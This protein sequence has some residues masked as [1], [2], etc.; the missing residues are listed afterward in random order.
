MNYEYTSTS[1][2]DIFPVEVPEGCGWR[3]LGHGKRK[4]TI[5]TEFYWFWEREAPPAPPEPEVNHDHDDLFG[6]AR[7]EALE[8]K[9]SDLRKLGW[10][11][12]LVTAADRDTPMAV[13]QAR[14]ALKAW[15][16]AT[17]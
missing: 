14:A 1:S 4:A 15:E 13:A 9:V 3:M 10:D 7:I 8:Q 16:K 2:D 6:K 17:Q 5:N 11:L 12:Y